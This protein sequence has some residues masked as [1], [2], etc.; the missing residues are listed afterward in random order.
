MMKFFGIYLMIITMTSIFLMGFDKRKAI[1][2]QFRIA[3][4]TLLF[5]TL[6]GGSVGILI[7][8]RLF[9]HKIRVRKFKY[10]VPVIA[11]LHFGVF[12]YLYFTFFI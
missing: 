3:E 6:V 2:R 9:R 11:L 7:G 4:S 10:G 5:C 8:M 12:I 1:R